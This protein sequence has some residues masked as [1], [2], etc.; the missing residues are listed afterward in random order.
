[1][2][3][4]WTM[5][6]N[7]LF[8]WNLVNKIAQ[9]NFTNSLSMVLTLAG[10]TDVRSM[11]FD[12]LLIVGIHL[13]YEFCCDSVTCI[14]ASLELIA[15]NLAYFV[16]TAVTLCNELCA[17]CYKAIV[18]QASLTN[19]LSVRLSDILFMLISFELCWC[20]LQCHKLFLNKLWYNF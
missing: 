15:D 5:L 14:D 2:G 6:Y 7:I 18:L 11:L 13:W 10:S 20:Q 9:G 1:M 12:G 4:F 16:G 19:S 8:L 17:Y 3:L